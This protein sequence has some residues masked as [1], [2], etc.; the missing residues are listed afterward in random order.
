[1]GW[2]PSLSIASLGQQR[3]TGSSQQPMRFLQFIYMFSRNH[4]DVRIGTIFFILYIYWSKSAQLFLPVGTWQKITFTSQMLGY[5]S[6]GLAI[7]VVFLRRW[8]NQLN[9][10]TRSTQKK[11]PEPEVQQLPGGGCLTS[12]SFYTCPLD[13]AWVF[14]SYLMPSHFIGILSLGPCILF[15]FLRGSTPPPPATDGG[16]DGVLFNIE[17]WGVGFYLVDVCRVWFVCPSTAR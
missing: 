15:Y 8:L 10:E 6:L 13:F 2:P 16:L 1:M 5:M 17:I 14:L 12:Y 3:H 11:M 7:L 4:P 9:K